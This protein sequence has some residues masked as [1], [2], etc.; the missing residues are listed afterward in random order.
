MDA[1]ADIFVLLPNLLVTAIVLF[2]GSGLVL[3]SDNRADL[4]MN[5]VAAV[6]VM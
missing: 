4:V 5:S 3:H 2:A 6:F 1:R